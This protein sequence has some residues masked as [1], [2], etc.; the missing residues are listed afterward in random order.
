[1]SH[2]NHSHTFFIYITQKFH[3]FDRRF[4]VECTGRLI[5]QNHLRF[6]NQGTGNGYTL[7]AVVVLDDVVEGVEG[8]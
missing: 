4:T 5:S 8:V 1:M 2:D 7:F 3:Y 6:S